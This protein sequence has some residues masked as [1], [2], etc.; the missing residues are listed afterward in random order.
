MRPHKASIFLLKLLISSASGSVCKGRSLCSSEGMCWEEPYAR[1]RGDK[2]E[3]CGK[4]EVVAR[5]SLL[6]FTSL[7]RLCGERKASWCCRH[8]ITDLP[9]S[10]DHEQFGVRPGSRPGLAHRCIPDHEHHAQYAGRISLRTGR[11]S[12]LC[13]F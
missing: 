9:W 2:L 10:R 5:R 11:L 4:R 6:R 13:S 1:T 7:I 12:C 3:G 8:R